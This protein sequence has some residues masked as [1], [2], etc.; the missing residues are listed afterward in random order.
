MV[1]LTAGRNVELMSQQ[2]RKY[3]PQL[4]VM[5]D[6]KGAQALKENL[7]F[8]STEILYGEEG[9]LAAASLTPLDL[10]LVAVVGAVGIRPTLAAIDQGTHIALANKETFGG[11]RF[12]RHGTGP[13]AGCKDFTG[14][15][16]T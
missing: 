14:G 2:V 4:A 8:T 11:R 15:L 3:R 5:G 10:C 13:P 9:L 16:G 12:H 1:A 6:A 7:G